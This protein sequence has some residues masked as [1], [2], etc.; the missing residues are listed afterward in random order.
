MVPPAGITSNS[1]LDLQ[2]AFN[3]DLN[4][5]FEA[6]QDCQELLEASGVELE[7]LEP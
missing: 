1:E 7:D 4:G 2:N 3:G 5:V 6:L